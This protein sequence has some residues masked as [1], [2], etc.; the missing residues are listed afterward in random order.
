MAGELPLFSNAH[1]GWWSELELA[2]SIEIIPLGLVGVPGGGIKLSPPKL[3]MA[4][5]MAGPR[6]ILSPAASI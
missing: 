3:A 2:S 6:S 1:G 5:G 4:A